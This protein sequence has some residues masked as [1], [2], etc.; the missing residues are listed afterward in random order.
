M[1]TRPTRHRHFC[2]RVKSRHTLPSVHRIRDVAQSPTGPWPHASLALR[3]LACSQSN[4]TRDV[5]H[6]PTGPW[7]HGPLVLRAPP[8]PQSTTSATRRTSPRFR[9]R[10]CFVVASLDARDYRAVPTLAISPPVPTLRPNVSLLSCAAGSVWERGREM[11]SVGRKNRRRRDA[12]RQ[13]KT[14]CR[15]PYKSS[16]FAAGNTPPQTGVDDVAPQTGYR[17]SNHMKA[18]DGLLW[19]RGCAGDQRSL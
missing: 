7:P 10:F 17:T 16:D 11:A 13:S 15:N 6:G 14:L 5:A 1:G 8:L 18:A 2:Q 12:S 4:H 3:V 19:T 9:Q